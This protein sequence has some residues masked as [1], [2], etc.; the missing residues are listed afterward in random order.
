MRIVILGAFRDELTSII[1]NFLHLKETMISKCR[2]LVAQWNKHDIIISLAGVGTSASAITTTILC[3]TLGPDL[4]IFCGVAGGLKADQQIGDLVLANKIIDAD[5]HQL[6]TLLPNT[7]YKNALIDPHTLTTITGEYILHSS[8]FKI[9][10]SF[11][12]ERLKTGIIVTSNTFPAPKILFSE[13]K[14]LGCSAIEMES[15]SVFKAAEY[16]DVPVITLRAISNLLDDEG[17]SLVTRPDALDVC[18]KKL[19]LCLT[20]IL[21]HTQS[22]E[23]IAEF[24]QHQKISELIAKYELIPH[25]EGG[26]YRQTF[27]SKDVVKAEGDASTRYLGESRAAGTSIIYLLSQGDFSGWHTVQSDETWSFHAGEDLL[28]RIIDSISGELKEIILGIHRGDLQFT[29]R[30]GDIFSAEPL[31]RFCL[32]GCVVTPGFDSKDFKLFTRE[33]FVT[34]YPQH[35]E[36]A[37]LA[38]DKPVVM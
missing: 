6:P 21:N 25:P 12:F 18:T 34:A 11:S 13:I 8:L 2:C 28:L 7:P 23:T 38:R 31:G 30:A 9:I 27:R 10:S 20:A 29:V 15:G 33:E 4:I 5:L 17:N 19:A 3:E 36:L 32:T 1:K 14:R 24:N 35:I 26:W 37:R 16:Y 22:L